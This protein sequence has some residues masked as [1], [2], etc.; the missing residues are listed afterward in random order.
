MNTVLGN[1]CAGS[2]NH[3]VANW[4]PPSPFAQRARRRAGPETSHVST[5]DGDL[6]QVAR[7]GCPPLMR[8]LSRVSFNAGAVPPDPPCHLFSRRQ[9]NPF[10]GADFRAIKR[11]LHVLIFGQATS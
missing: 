4:F 5:P 7:S 11:P 1:S 6:S 10:A 8:F 2:P 3:A 9:V